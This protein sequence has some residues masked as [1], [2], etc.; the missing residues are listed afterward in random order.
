MQMMTSTH[1]IEKLNDVA[2]W[3]A[4]LTRDKTADALFVYAVRSTGV[5][6]RPSCPSRRP[7]P[8]R[9]AFYD[10]TEEAR[11]A[12]YRACR[13]CRPDAQSPIDPWIEKVHRATVYLANV[14]GHPP[15]ATLASRLGGSPYHVQ[16]NFKRLVGVSPR[17]YAEACRLERVKRHLKHGE[18]VTTAMMDAGYGSTS[19]FY[20]RAAPMLGMSPSA[21]RKG[22][23]GTDIRYAIVD[24]PLGR[25]LVA[26]TTRGVCTVALGTADGDLARSLGREYPAASIVADSGGL[27]K[28]TKAI[29]AHLD[30]RRP[31]LDLPLDVQATAFQWQVWQ[32]L[33]A[34]PYGETR[35]YGEVA[36]SIGRPRAVR[37]VARACA[38]NPVALAIPCHR[39]VPAAGG[40]GG[41]RWGASRK[42]AILAR[43]RKERSS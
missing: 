17:E 38:T 4:V 37:A 42:R 24:S 39:V 28:W 8:D 2:R 16:R 30:G 27:S 25:L 34:I 41:Y 29:L 36:Q 19:R 40:T 1:A 10:S 21:Y 22:G 15:L 9:V 6:C 11:H 35:T 18:A 5:Y 20:E 23:A 43:E 33:A 3:R 7:R 32:A 26:S 14:D 12:G 31:R 13:R